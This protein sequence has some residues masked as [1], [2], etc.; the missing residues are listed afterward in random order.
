MNSK[1]KDKYLSYSQ[2]IKEQENKE[3]L[4][5]SPK[6][7]KNYSPLKVTQ[8]KKDRLPTIQ[9][10]ETENFSIKPL[11]EEKEIDDIII[12][13][14]MKNPATNQT[15]SIE[16][17]INKSKD[18]KERLEKS[19]K[20]DVTLPSKNESP[21]YS[22]NTNKI[23]NNNNYPISE[24]N[25]PQNNVAPSIKNKNLVIN[26]INDTIDQKNIHSLRQPHLSDKIKTNVINSIQDTL[27]EQIHISNQP[28]KQKMNKHSKINSQSRKVTGIYNAEIE[29]LE[30]SL[31]KSIT[32]LDKMYEREKIKNE[33]I[34]D[35]KAILKHEIYNGF[36]DRV[37][38]YNFVSKEWGQ[39]AFLN[40]TRSS[41]KLNTNHTTNT[42]ESEK[43]QNV[44]P[45]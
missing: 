34:K 22:N 3:K 20:F 8:S 30:E 26:S 17:N 2:K 41:G 37:S 44:R 40:K 1:N 31:V 38:S 25:F 24:N 14:R 7:D 9:E 16:A 45:K 27:I 36:I 42:F 23:I 15:N 12:K 32:D 33:K 10:R 19:I 4:V 39:I 29:L 18:S 28:I 43:P 11:T 6:F 35:K 21:T 13:Q 5:N